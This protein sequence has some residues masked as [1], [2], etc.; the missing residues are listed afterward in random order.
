MFEVNAI[1]IFTDGVI[2]GHTAYMLDDY[3]DEPGRGEGPWPQDKL[4]EVVTKADALGV[5]VHTHA[6]GDAAV[7]QAVDAYEVAEETNG[8]KGKNRHAITHLQVVDPEDITRMGELGVIAV[9]NSYWFCREPGYFTELEYPYL[10]PVTGE[11]KYPGGRAFSEY[12]M[13][14]FYDAG[15]TVTMA[16]DYPVTVPSRPIDAIEA[17][18]LRI[19]RYGDPDTELNPAKD[20]ASVKPVEEDGVIVGF[21]G[22]EADPDMKQNV[23]LEQM[24]DSASRAGAYALFAE[25]RYGMLEVGMEADLVVLDKDLFKIDPAE[26]GGN[27]LPYVLS[28]DEVAK[29]GPADYGTTILE[30]ILGGKSIYKEEAAQ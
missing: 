15:C 20:V 9:V 23:T 16:S 22:Y 8:A 4:N 19:D 21:T 1:K 17:G 28:E 26:I 24:L 7:K 5:T 27:E 25:D 13:K 11:G 14:S 10:G 12:P 2:E 3:Y 6:I 30:V 18:I 29:L